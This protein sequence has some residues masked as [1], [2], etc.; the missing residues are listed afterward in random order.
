[1]LPVH[2]AG[3]MPAG[4]TGRAHPRAGPDVPKYLNSP[5]T[6]AYK[7]GSLLFGLHHARPALAREATPVIVEG[8]FDAIAVTTADPGRLAGLAP[9][10][11][12]LTSQQVALIG[13]AADLDR[14]GVL[15]AFDSDAA[16]R[17]ATL[18]AYGILLPLTPKLQT[19]LLDGK[20]PAEILQQ[21]GPAAL[22]GPARPPRAAVRPAHRRQDRVMGTTAGRP[23]Q[24]V[25]GNAE[26]R[27]AD[28]RP[29]AG[30]DHPA[31]PP[32]HRRQGTPDV[33]DQLHHVD[34]PELPQIAR[35]LPADTAFQTVRTAAKLDLDVSDVLTM[36]ANA[37][38]LS[39]RSPKGQEPALRDNPD[40]TR[41]ALRREAPRLAGTSFPHPPLSP[42]ASAVST[43][44]GFHS[45]PPAS[46]LRRPAHR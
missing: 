18:R 7:K 40:R 4:F 20:D 42:H 44:S 26:R 28:R 2:D 3:G 9:C 31:D 16:G 37:V 45:R 17:K 6:A 38:T 36:V 8:P 34:N 30:R 23:G 39:A 24:P 10:G 41:P 19:A 35:I 25:P 11:T 46:A 12:A 5:E 15:V 33:D 14:T 22:R 21:H 27:R 32:H 43:G 1:M 13:Q 29:P